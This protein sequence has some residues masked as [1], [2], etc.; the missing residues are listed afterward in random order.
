MTIL[1]QNKLKTNKRLSILSLSEQQ[2]I[3]QLP[4][5]TKEEQIIYFSLNSTEEKILNEELPGLN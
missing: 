2:S 1:E 4:N 3:Y 5:F